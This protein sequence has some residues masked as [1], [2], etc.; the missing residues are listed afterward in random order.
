MARLELPSVR[1]PMRA[2]AAAS[3]A[4]GLIAVL[5][6]GQYFQMRRDEA[7]LEA[8][9]AEQK[10][11]ASELEELKKITS[12]YEPVLYVGGTD[13]IDLYVDLRETKGQRTGGNNQILSASTNMTTDF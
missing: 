1:K 6:G 5:A 11:I 2:V 8:L 9:R 7:R 10:K 4:A 12:A 3:I 13:D